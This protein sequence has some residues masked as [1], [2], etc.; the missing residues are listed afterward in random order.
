M[1]EPGC[2]QDLIETCGPS[3]T[4]ATNADPSHGLS[5]VQ[6]KVT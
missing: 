4:L 3:H 6:E 1:C 5:L 2:S